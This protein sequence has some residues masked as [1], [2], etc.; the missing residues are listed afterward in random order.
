MNLDRQLLASAA[1]KGSQLTF[2]DV[3][4]SAPGSRILSPRCVLLRCDT[5]QSAATLFAKSETF[6]PD[7]SGW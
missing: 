3:S 6:D 7:F 2:F 1:L 5:F 4:G